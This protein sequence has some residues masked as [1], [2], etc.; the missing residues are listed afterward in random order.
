MPVVRLL[1]V[2]LAA[3]ALDCAAMPFPVRLGS[4]RLVLDTPPGFSDTT[5]L[6]SPR[7]QELGETLTSPSNRILLFAITDADRRRFVNGDQIE[8]KRYMV[9]VTPRGLEAQR[10]SEAQ[11]TQYVSDSLSALG[12]PAGT[13]DY[14]KYLD[15]QEAGLA[16]LIEELRREPA[17]VTVM[18]GSRLPP[19]PAAGLAGIFNLGPEKPTQYLFST[20]TLMLVRGKALQ[21]SVY[22]GYSSAADIDFLKD[23]TARWVTELIRLNGR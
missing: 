16:V 19:V 21:L 20:T 14:L 7:L 3:L 5:D 23:I 17:V 9:A 22:A 11:F 12:K 15:R 6:Y 1:A 13:T 18:Q 10:L 2:L 4:E 8:A